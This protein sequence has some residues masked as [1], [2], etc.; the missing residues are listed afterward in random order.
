ML[1]DCRATF[2]LCIVAQTP[3]CNTETNLHPIMASFVCATE[4]GRV[5]QGGFLPACVCVCVCVCVCATNRLVQYLFMCPLRHLASAKCCSHFLAHPPQIHT[6]TQTHTPTQSLVRAHG[7]AISAACCCMCQGSAPI[8]HI[9]SWCREET[10][11]RRETL[12]AVVS[13]SWCLCVWVSFWQ[14]LCF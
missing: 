3:P 2:N 13:V 8:I 5:A 4:C 7:H 12:R 6:P 9:D 14:L 1:T 11:P 10:T